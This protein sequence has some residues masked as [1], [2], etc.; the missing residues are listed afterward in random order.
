MIDYCDDT[1]SHD[2]S[3]KS[4]H[5]A[6]LGV[7][8]VKELANRLGCYK[9]QWLT[10]CQRGTRRS[11]LLTCPGAQRKQGAICLRCSR[12]I[13][14]SEHD[15]QSRKHQSSMTADSHRLTA[16][17]HLFSFF[18]HSLTYSRCLSFSLFFYMWKMSLLLV[19]RDHNPTLWSLTGPRPPLKLI[20][21]ISIVFANYTQSNLW[22]SQTIRTLSWDR[23]KWLNLGLSDALTGSCTCASSRQAR[24]SAFYEALSWRGISTSNQNAPTK[25]QHSHR[26]I[27]PRAGEAGRGFCSV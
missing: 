9:I 21:S 16:I 19:S 4:S 23:G 1:F 13:S 3:N 10:T 11:A 24:R 15:E 27:D 17:R 26:K 25:S 20:C 6:Y 22:P 8:S 12:L 14:L 5:Y 2:Y 7:G 18:S